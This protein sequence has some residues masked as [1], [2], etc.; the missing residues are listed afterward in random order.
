MKTGSTSDRLQ[1]FVADFR[2]DVGVGRTLG[3]EDREQEESQ[4]LHQVSA[5]PLAL[6]PFLSLSP[7]PS[8][9]AKLYSAGAGLIPTGGLG[10]ADEVLP[11]S[12]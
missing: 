7:N 1:A 3:R 8:A 6:S 9:L 5:Q 12:G 2:Q 4:R 11:T 10:A